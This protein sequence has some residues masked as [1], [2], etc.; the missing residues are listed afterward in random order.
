MFVNTFFFSDNCAIQISS[1]PSNSPFPYCV[2]YKETLLANR[3][4]HDS[5]GKPASLPTI[6][7]PE[8]I[9]NHTFC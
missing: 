8:V 5:F 4:P 3:S 9:A 1:L 6:V 7:L 2:I